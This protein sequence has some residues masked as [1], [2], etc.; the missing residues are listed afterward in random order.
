MTNS[1]K[2]SISKNV[3]PQGPVVQDSIYSIPQSSQFRHCSLATLFVSCRFPK[4]IQFYFNSCLKISVT[5]NRR[6]K[7]QVINL[8]CARGFDRLKRRL[9]AVIWLFR[10]IP[11]FLLHADQLFTPLLDNGF[12]SRIA[13]RDIVCCFSRPWSARLGQLQ[14]HLLDLECRCKLAPL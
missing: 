13:K 2:A 14:P 9:S 8:L 4:I 1:C 12:Q 10:L 11:F 3:T 7:P 6:I 5:L